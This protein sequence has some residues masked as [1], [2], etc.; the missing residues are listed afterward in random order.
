L[1]S[2]RV[3]FLGVC[4]IRTAKRFQISLHEACTM[5][6]VAKLNLQRLD[7]LPMPCLALLRP[8]RG[9]FGVIVLFVQ[10]LAV[11]FEI[12]IKINDLL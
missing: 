9:R 6:H 12:T 3:E 7:L 2:Q 11:C 8:A 4:R 1:Q 5:T 10:N